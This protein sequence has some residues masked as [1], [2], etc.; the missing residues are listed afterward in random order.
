M[1]RPRISVCV[2]TYNHRRY[3]AD[4]LLSVLSQDV[5]ADVEVWVGDDMSDDGASDIIA[6]LAKDMAGASHIMSS[7][8]IDRGR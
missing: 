3:I 6:A 8:P 2:S 7:I 4:C 5:D 1:T